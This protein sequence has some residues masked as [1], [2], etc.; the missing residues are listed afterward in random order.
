[1]FVTE[2]AWNSVA[3]RERMAEIMFEE[4]RVPAFYIANTGVLSA[5]V[6]ATILLV[7]CFHVF[8]LQ[9]EGSP[10]E[11]ARLWSSTLASLQQ[12]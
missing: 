8:T 3:N 11:R 10:Q 12:A 9:F 2:P 7:S 6:Y 1:M 4:F 5:Y